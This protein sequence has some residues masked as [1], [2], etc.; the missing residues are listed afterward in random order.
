M[1][2]SIHAQAV[3]M[4]MNMDDTKI[5]A[6][7]IIAIEFSGG[8]CCKN[9]RQD[10]DSQGYHYHHVRIFFKPLPQFPHFYHY[11]IFV[12]ELIPKLKIDSLNLKFG[13]ISRVCD[14]E[15]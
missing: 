11:S 8:D 1:D 13:I 9:K 6:N 10:H 2:S 7:I 12:N 3:G 15:Q 14:P 4:P 5:S